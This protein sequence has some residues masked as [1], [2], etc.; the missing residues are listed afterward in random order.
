MGHLRVQA[1]IPAA[2]MGTRLLSATKEQPKEMLPVFA[3]SEGRVACVKPLLQ[4]IFEQLFE[5]GVREF[6]FI[7]GRGK[8]AIE[9]HFTPDRG[10]IKSLQS[11]GSSSQAAQ[12]LG[13]Y[14]K[15]EASA[16]VWLNQPEPRGFGDAVLRAEPHVGDGPF[17]VHAG[18][19]YIISKR[20]NILTRLEAEHTENSADATLAV[21][22]VRDPRQYGVVESYLTKRGLLEVASVIEKPARPRSR[23]AIM[24]LYVFN[25]SIFHALRTT[26]PDKKGEIQLTDGIQNLV[27]AGRRVQ[28]VKLRLD[29]VRLDIG[30]PENYW[31]ALRLSY[32]HAFRK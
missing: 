7:V 5:F 16:I 10:F 2:G 4:L 26:T 29:D 1:V 32:R 12:L 3:S 8:R 30:T 15:I 20:R 24:P 13:F 25:K 14:E 17:F 22:T 9:D 19:T 18:D 23:L 6:F 28:A 27:K 31:E 21:Q 11:S